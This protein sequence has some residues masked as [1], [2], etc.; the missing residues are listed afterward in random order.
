MRTAVLKV[1]SSFSMA[2]GSPSS[3]PNSPTLSP[4]MAPTNHPD[5]LRFEVH[6]IPSRAGSASGQQKWYLKASH[7]GEVARWIRVLAR[8]IEVARKKEGSWS[9]GGVVGS[10]SG[11][12]A[13]SGGGSGSDVDARPRN[14]IDS[15]NDR[16]S[17][18]SVVRKGLQKIGTSKGS[19]LASAPGSPMLTSAVNTNVVAS[20]KRSPVSSLDTGDELDYSSS[21]AHV[22][23]GSTIGDFPHRHGSHGDDEDEDSD[24]DDIS[25]DIL[26]ESSPPHDNSYILQGNALNAQVDLNTQLLGEYLNAINGGVPQS[27]GRSQSSF[28]SNAQSSS[29]AQTQSALLEALNATRQ[30]VNEFIKMSNEREEWFK[31]KLEK[32]KERGQVWEE[33]LQMVVREGDILEKE[34]KKRVRG[35]K[36]RDSRVSR[37]RSSSRLRTAASIR[38]MSA[39]PSSVQSISPLDGIPPKMSTPARVISPLVTSPAEAAIFTP[40]R[41]MISSADIVNDEDTAVDEA[42]DT[43]DEDEFFDAIESNNLPNL[44]VTSVLTSP[45][46]ILEKS[47]PVGLVDIQQYECYTNLRTKLPISEDKRP[48]TSLWSVLKHSIGKDLTKISFPVFF[49]EP[50]SMLQRMVRLIFLSILP[51]SHHSIFL[52]GGRYG[53]F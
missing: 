39:V 9:T 20:G 48:P 38:P 12:G 34:L 19:T 17:V 51:E 10:A 2:T 15:D 43:D 53:I 45:S 18:R 32:E 31:R 8:N 41:L 49:N 24:D 1:P 14:S 29:A 33:S 36:E 13:G 16:K 11:L 5:K 44:V 35:E 37:E 28:N 27:S 42:V 6:S 52:L 26:S 21:Q 47:L 3:T 30:M 23:T 7:A 25:E 46:S 50:T 22:D 4:F 40:P